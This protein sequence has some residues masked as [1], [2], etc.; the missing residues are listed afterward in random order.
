MIIGLSKL[1]IRMPGVR[2][3][4]ERRNIVKSFIKKAKNS[5]NISIVEIESHPD[6]K[7][8]AIGVVF[9]ATNRNSLDY[10]FEEIEKKAVSSGEIQIVSFEKNIMELPW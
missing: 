6:I 5:H 9:F 2:T 1:Q 4:K 7:Q 3:L 8:A 10:V